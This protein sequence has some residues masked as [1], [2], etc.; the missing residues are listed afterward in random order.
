MAYTPH[1][2]EQTR[3]MLAALGLERVEQLFA[4]Q[5]PEPLRLK[6]PLDIPPGLS[7]L[8]LRR[9]FSDLAGR[10]WS[11]GEQICFLGA[12]LYDHYVPSVIPTLML[13]G[14]FHTAYTPYQPEMS[15]GT[16]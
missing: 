13:R 15:Q 14:E 5:I 2:P 10:N 11:A 16:L 8:E 6:R 7:E 12:G 3:E 4:E 9:L 1:T